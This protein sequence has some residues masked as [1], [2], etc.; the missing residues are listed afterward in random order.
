MSRQIKYKNPE[1]VYYDLLKDSYNA[2]NKNNIFFL[3]FVTYYYSSDSELISRGSLKGKIIGID[4][5]KEE[6]KKSNDK[7]EDKQSDNN[8]DRLFIPAF[9]F[10]ITSGVSNGE[11][12]IA[13]FLDLDR[14]IGGLWF[15][16]L[17]SGLKEYNLDYYKTK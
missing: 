3:V 17:S 12:V 2:R 1:I 14:K 10:N 8:Y 6:I 9:P 5:S 4:I 15:N 13:S 7:F 16:R 11:I